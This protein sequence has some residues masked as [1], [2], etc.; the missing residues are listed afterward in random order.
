MRLSQRQKLIIAILTFCLTGYVLYSTFS[1]KAPTISESVPLTDSA[2]PSI[3]V[4]DSLQDQDILGVA[5]IFDSITPDTSLFA[6]VVFQSLTDSNAVV[7]Q[8]SIGRP[9]PF[10]EIGVDRI[11]STTTPK[12]IKKK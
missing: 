5:R 9:N 6:S 8:E 3:T 10:S 12:T 7:S 1:T 11:V 2:M 4:T